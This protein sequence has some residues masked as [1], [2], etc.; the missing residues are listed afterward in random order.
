ML[1]RE[2]TRVIPHSIRILRKISTGPLA[3]NI[4]LNHLRILVLIKE[5]KGQTQISDILQ[6]SLPAVS[7]MLSNLVSKKMITRQRGSD[8]RTYQ[9]GLT[10]K[11]EKTL[12]QVTGYTEARIDEALKILS[13]KERGQLSHGLKAL[14]KLMNKMA[15]VK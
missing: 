11:G 5:G 2:I 3:G 12:E 6:I 7:K 14:E 13:T 1:T 4:T 9:L 8:A 10:S 15:E